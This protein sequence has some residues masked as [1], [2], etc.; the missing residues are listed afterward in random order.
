MGSLLTGMIL[1]AR[2]RVVDRFRAGDA[3]SADFSIARPALDDLEGREWDSM[4]RQ[5][6]IH[7]VEH[8]QYYLDIERMRRGRKR[9]S[10]LV[11]SAVW[12]PVVFIA[13]FALARLLRSAN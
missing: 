1:A 7:E 13:L 12:I 6:L 4:I 10:R 8:E 2:E 5:G 3:Y 11:T 9:L